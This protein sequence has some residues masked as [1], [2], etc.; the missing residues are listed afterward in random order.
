MMQDLIKQPDGTV[1]VLG[2]N[3]QILSVQLDGSWQWRPLGTAGDYERA[4]LNGSVIVFD[5]STQKPFPYPILLS[6]V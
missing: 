3:D 2:Y 5:P 4:T 1:T 6:V